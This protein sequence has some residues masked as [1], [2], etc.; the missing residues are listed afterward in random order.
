MHHAEALKHL[1]QFER[2]D[3]V[4]DGAAAALKLDAHG[5]WIVSGGRGSIVCNC[6]LFTIH[7]GCRSWR[8]WAYAKRTLG[9]LCSIA[10]DGYDAGSLRLDRLPVDAEE[11]LR[12][13]V[14]LRQR[15]RGAADHLELGLK[16]GEPLLE[17]FGLRLLCL[18][19]GAAHVILSA[20]AMHRARRCRGRWQF[21]WI[22][23]A[24]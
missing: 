4:I 21:P 3:S 20:E 2:A 5:D 1:R 14:G 12:H 9:G 19:V 22:S 24:I 6:G 23:S 17:V 16:T 15:R 11:A 18:L 13:A 8:H 7:V 10:R